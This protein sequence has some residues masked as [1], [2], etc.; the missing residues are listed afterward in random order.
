MSLDVASP[1]PIKVDLY[2]T[3]TFTY[4]VSI[5][6]QTVATSNDICSRLNKA[7]YTFNN[8]NIFWSIAQYSKEQ[9]I[10]HLKE[11]DSGDGQRQLGQ[12]R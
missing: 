6:S 11:K 3:A 4:L 7:R 5:I 8:M 12:G 1:A 2:N 9:S 10:G